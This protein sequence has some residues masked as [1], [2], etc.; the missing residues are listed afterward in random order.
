MGICLNNPASC[1][2]GAAIS[3]W[4]KTDEVETEY[5]TILC[6]YSPH[7]IGFDIERRSGFS[8]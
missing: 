3:L 8:G 6:I 4:T 7:R 2:E 1:S 5:A